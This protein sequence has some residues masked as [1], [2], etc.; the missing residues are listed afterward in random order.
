MLLRKLL[1]VACAGFLAA[2]GSPNG[3]VVS[4]QA[5]AVGGNLFIETS[6]KGAQ[7]LVLDGEITPRTSYTFLA[8][9]ETARVEGLVIAQSPGGDLLASHQIGRAIKSRRMN[10]VVLASCISACV[11][12]FV[13]GK[14][15]EMMDFAQLGV[16][17]ATNRDVAY[18]IDRKYWR[19]MG[20]SNINEKAY[21]VPNNKLWIIK[22]Q[23]ARE[24][25]LATDIIRSDPR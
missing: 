18:Q 12:V 11:D 22:S 1:V 14:R 21:R 23:R 16:H 4:N 24:L 8:L 3:L 9:I 19:E 2:C 15:R 10:T 17:S 25:R 7:F 20:F 6:T 5:Q 13:A